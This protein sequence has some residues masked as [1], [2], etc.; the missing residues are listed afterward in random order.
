[1]QCIFHV[2]DP[3]QVICQWFEGINTI[4]KGW[5]SHDENRGYERLLV[6]CQWQIVREMHPYPVP[7]LH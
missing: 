1:M 4:Y 7:E 2:D 6:V 5:N 3:K